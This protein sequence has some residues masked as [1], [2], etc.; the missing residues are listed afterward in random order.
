MIARSVPASQRGRTT[1]WAFWLA[2]L[3]SGCDQPLNFSGLAADQASA[4]ASQSLEFDVPA[5][6]WDK[7]A[8]GEFVVTG[9]RLGFFRDASA[10]PI[11]TRDVGRDAVVVD[12]RTARVVLNPP[13]L[14]Q[15]AGPISIRIQTLTR[16]G[17]S[18]W[19]AS[20]ALPATSGAPPGPASKSA[21]PGRSSLSISDVEPYPR[22]ADALRKLVPSPAKVDQLLASFR[23]INE[24]AQAV[25]ICT[26]HDVELGVLS[27]RMAG[28]PRRSLRRA[29]R[30]LQPTL[31]GA[32]MRKA[33][34]AAKQLLA[35]PKPPE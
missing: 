11:A 33:N 3:S 29:V 23:N 17:A 26:E 1:A 32:P 20:A 10:E 35:A 24:L 30:D 6:F 13:P 9:F 34:E 27:E 8:D 16:Q 21:R 31:L 19:S 12:G 14:G 4:R 22:L 18:P 25:A 15:E 28:P 7:T 5:Q 2:M